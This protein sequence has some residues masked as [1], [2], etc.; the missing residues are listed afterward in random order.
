MTVRA[1]V[2]GQTDETGHTRIRRRHLTHYAKLAAQLG[3][4]LREAP[5][6]EPA[7]RLRRQRPNMLSAAR[8]GLAQSDRPDLRVKLLELADGLAELRKFDGT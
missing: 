8:W 7:E 4:A 2:A 1:F 6:A 5:G 3:A